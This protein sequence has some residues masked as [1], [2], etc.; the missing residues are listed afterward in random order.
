MSELRQRIIVSM[1]FIPLLLAGIFYSGAPLVII[2][3]LMVVLGT[4]EFVT[5]LKNR[6]MNLSPLVIPLAAIVY[7]LL[8]YVRGFDIELLVILFMLA[9]LIKIF[10]WKKDN[11]LAT[12]FAAMWGLFYTAV[13]PAMVVRIGL[14]YKS[15]FILLVLIL[16]I[17]IV[18]SVAYF[19]GM[20]FGK[21]R[22]VTEIS[23]RKSVEGFIAGAVTPF[24]IVGILQV[25]RF[26]LIPLSHLLLIAFSAGVI[27]QMGDLVESMLKRYCGVKDSSNLIPGHGGI[28]DRTDSILVAG[29]FLYCALIFLDKVR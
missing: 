23:P 7:L 14:D 13:V 20:N 4:L 24:V 6:E 3:L 5:M 17:W 11:N 28:L 10:R 29:S 12:N 22:G 25:V 8:V 27:G 9:N 2:F 15:E 1:I 19:I 26:D 18:D 21:H 16:M